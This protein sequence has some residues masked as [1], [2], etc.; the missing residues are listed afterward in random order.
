MLLKLRLDW[1]VRW[2]RKIPLKLVTLSTPKAAVQDD[3]LY[4]APHYFLLCFVITLSDNRHN[5]ITYAK[6]SMKAGVF[7]S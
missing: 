5:V 4:S 6:A 3:A 1:A 2:R 7:V